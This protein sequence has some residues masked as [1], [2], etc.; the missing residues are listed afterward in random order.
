[1]IFVTVGGQLP[2]DRLVRTVDEWAAEHG[3]Q[4]V[5]AQIGGGGYEPRHVAWERFLSPS[6]FQER[7][8]SAELVVGHAGVGTI[9][10]S[11]ELQVPLVVFPRRA[12]HR[13]HRSVHQLGTARYF[14]EGG[15]VVAAYDPAELVRCIDA[16]LRD[17]RAGAPPGPASPEL[18]A[19]I[20]AHVRPGH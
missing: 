18:V 2:F 12:E 1:M 7:M 11:L 10:T 8:T 20:R 17:G 6:E 5:F 16:A 4:D 9:L 14:A 19:R 15:H 3:R 13:E